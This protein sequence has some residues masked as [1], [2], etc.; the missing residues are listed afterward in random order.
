MKTSDT[1]EEDSET[2]KPVDEG[3]IQTEFSSDYYFTA[4]IYGQ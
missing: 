4:Q 3:E 2:P 1:T